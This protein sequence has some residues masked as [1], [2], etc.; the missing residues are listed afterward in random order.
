MTQDDDDDDSHK[1]KPEEFSSVIFWLMACVWGGFAGVAGPILLLMT[2]MMFDAPG[3]ADNP[4]NHLVVIS[5]LTIPAAAF[6]APFAAYPFKKE[7]KTRMVMAAFFGIPAIPVGALVIFT[8][9]LNVFCGG[10]TSC[11]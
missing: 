7:G 4:D 8:L 1:H 10:Q 11:G 2:V 6:I 5:L 9:T 3:S